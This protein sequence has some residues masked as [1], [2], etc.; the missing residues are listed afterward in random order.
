MTYGVSA[1][2]VRET[3]HIALRDVTVRV[4]LSDV[5]VVVGGDGAGKTSLVRTMVGELVPQSGEVRLPDPTDIGYLPAST[6]SWAALTVQQ[7]LEFAAGAY[8]LHGA[9][10]RQRCAE[11]LRAADLAGTEHRLASQLSGGMRRKLGFCM[12]IAHRPSLLVL[13]EPTTGID[14]VSRIDLWRMISGAAADG[15]AV[16][17]STTYLDEAER[18]AHIVVL[19]DGA[20]LTQ[21]SLEDVLATF[22]GSVTVTDDPMRREWAWR[23]GRV[24]HEYWP[25]GVSGTPHG[26]VQVPDLEDVVMAASLRKVRSAA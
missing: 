18:A 22:V 15:A 1:A 7:N 10:M 4:P 13:D 12:A 14:P 16:L 25:D 17:M 9:T 2:T 23:R 11:L 3:D 6:G 21:G 24:F 26:S 5:V 8:G 19:D 20:V